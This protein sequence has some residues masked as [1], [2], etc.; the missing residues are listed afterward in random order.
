M[1]RKALRQRRSDNRSRVQKRR[2]TADGATPAPVQR[3][4]KRRQA[5]FSGG[6][7]IQRDYI[8]YF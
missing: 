7:V 5:S 8:R 6:N 2:A 4:T 3:P 1:R